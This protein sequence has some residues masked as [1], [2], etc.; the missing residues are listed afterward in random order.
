MNINRKKMFINKESIRNFIG[1]KSDQSDTSKGAS[2][3]PTDVIEG[4][5]TVTMI[6]SDEIFTRN[7]QFSR[8]RSIENT[9]DFHETL[10]IF[11]IKILK[12]KKL[13]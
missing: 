3:Q 10:C 4:I 11:F 12:L 7:S 1:S 8:H 2:N 9:T 5:I 13:P 6:D